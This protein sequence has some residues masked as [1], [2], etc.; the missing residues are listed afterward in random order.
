[1]SESIQGNDRWQGTH[2]EAQK[3]TS[4]TWPR[5]E[6]SEAVPL[7]AGSWKAGAFFGTG[8]FAAAPAT[9]ASTI[10]STTRIASDRNDMAP[11]MD[12]EMREPRGRVQPISR[13]TRAGQA[14]VALGR[15]K[16]LGFRS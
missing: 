15:G 10:G 3:S 6:S 5:K 14:Q 13:G 2:H 9:G 11:R 12:Y 1:M 16:R 7:R 4:T 8:G